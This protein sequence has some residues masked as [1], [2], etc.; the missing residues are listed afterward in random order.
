MLYL[1]FEV[2]EAPYAISSS[3][4]AEVLPLV[5]LRDIPKAPPF[6]AGLLNFHQR[7]I[8][9]IDLSQ[10]FTGLKA[11]KR[12][13][14]RIIL[15]HYRPKKNGS[16]LIGLMAEKATKTLQLQEEELKDPVVSINAAPY[17]GQL[18]LSSGEAI[19][20]VQVS[21]LLPEAVQTLLYPDKD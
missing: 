17:L 1:T 16:Q 4:V 11:R 12:R 3:D 19:Q 6:V 8:P 2:G 9:V 10:L 15:A 13:G 5:H 20:C 21:K 18:S 7:L 14:T